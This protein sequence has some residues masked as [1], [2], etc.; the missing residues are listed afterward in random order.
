MSSASDAAR[1]YSR[2]HTDRFVQELEEVLRI[3]SI[4]TDP[5]H[6]GDIER[7]AEWLAQNLR[8]L[9]A[10]NVAVMPTAG[11]PVVY[12][13]WLGAGPDKE[14]VLVYGHYDVVPASK[15][16]G[17][18]TEPFEPVVKD[19]KIFARGAT[20]DKGQLYI[21]VKALES[22][23]QTGDGP[24]VNL[25][26]I[27]EGEEEVSSPN[28]RPFIE[29]HLDLLKADVCVISDSSMPTMDRPAITHSLRGMT[30]VEIHVEGPHDDL[31]S[32]FYG[33]AVHNP[34]LALVEIL[35]AM[36]HPDHSIAVPGF[37]D[38]VVALTE[39]ER[40]EVAKTAISDAELMAATG[41]PAVWGDAAYT[42]TERV[43][44]RPT[45]EI[46][47]M[48]SGWTGPGPKTIIPAKAMAKV[49]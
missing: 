10:A 12:G 40:A 27:L 49:S 23:L 44:A 19:G 30:Y 25:K 47:G 41:V 13:E 37:Y 32:G 24:P 20:D 14:T 35:G 45:L 31:H 6:A 4:S 36:F 15:A 39:R 9:G 16:D 18:D 28:L 7:T 1:A 29:E 48:E 5:A 38:D 2:E 8:E 3:P 34:A 26:F 22:Y 11:Y 17:W 46:N 43:S 42:I 21:H 33:G